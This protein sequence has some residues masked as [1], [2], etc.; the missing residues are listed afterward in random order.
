MSHLRHFRDWTP[1]ADATCWPRSSW[2][3]R[4]VG[5]WCVALASF[6]DNRLTRVGS[7]SFWANSIFYSC[8]YVPSQASYRMTDSTK[9]KLAVVAVVAAEAVVVVVGAAAGCETTWIGCCCPGGGAAC[10]TTSLCCTIAPPRNVGIGRSPCRSRSCRRHCRSGCAAGWC[11]RWPEMVQSLGI[12]SDLGSVR[13]PIWGLFK[14]WKC[15]CYLFIQLYVCWHCHLL[16]QLGK[17]STACGEI[18]LQMRH[19]YTPARYPHPSKSFTAFIVKIASRCR[20]W[21]G[22]LVLAIEVDG[23]GK[24]NI[25]I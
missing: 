18:L 14:S 24:D 17:S 13:S 3:R 10:S 19:T 7:I 23:K 12:G 5:Q 15:V 2:T 8:S 9:N 22:C 20:Y 16:L 6:V 4:R 11:V 21:F 25:R 1:G